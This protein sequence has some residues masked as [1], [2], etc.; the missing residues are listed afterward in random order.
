MN[1]KIQIISDENRYFNLDFENLALSTINRFSALEAFDYT[2]IDLNYNKLW[3]YK[4][5]QRKFEEDINIKTLTD[6][7][8]ENDKIIIILPSNK[9]YNIT[10]TFSSETKQIKND[11]SIITK[12]LNDY[13]YDLS[14]FV[15]EKECINDYKNNLDILFRPLLL[16]ALSVLKL[17][18]EHELIEKINLAQ[19]QLLD[20][21]KGKTIL[22]DKQ[23]FLSRIEDIVNNYVVIIKQQISLF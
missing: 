13:F 12:F 11:T 8:K 18:D 7:I 21:I 14:K 2:L 9:E 20:Y 17:T 6:S 16:D 10:D 4:N 5:E 23:L 15:K 1:Y 3:N 19:K 22:L